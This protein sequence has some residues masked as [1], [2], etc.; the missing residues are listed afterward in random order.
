MMRRSPDGSREV[1]E[2]LVPVEGSLGRTVRITGLGLPPKIGIGA[3]DLPDNTW[4]DITN[5]FVN[6]QL[7]YDTV[8]TVLGGMMPLADRHL[9]GPDQMYAAR[10]GATFGI[11]KQ[12][13]PV[14]HPG[15][16]EFVEDDGN[17]PTMA[18]VVSDARSKFLLVAPAGMDSFQIA[19]AAAKAMCG[20]FIVEMITSGTLS[21]TEVVAA[22]GW[23]VRIVPQKLSP[24]AALGLN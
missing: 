7:R 4:L 14:E 11:G 10:S 17:K 15:E 24:E 13:T 8:E 1:I 18:W 23:R 21:A 16:V 22:P 5:R 2:M 20:E 6:G 3:F 12:K 19:D 9:Q